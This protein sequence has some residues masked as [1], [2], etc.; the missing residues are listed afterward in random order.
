[1]TQSACNGSNSDEKQRTHLPNP[2]AYVSPLR[3]EAVPRWRPNRGPRG[4]IFGW[5]LPLQLMRK[6]CSLERSCVATGQGLWLLFSGYLPPL[7]SS[8]ASRLPITAGSRWLPIAVCAS[9][10]GDSRR[11]NASAYCQQLSIGESKFPLEV[12]IEEAPLKRRSRG[13]RSR[14]P[15][16]KVLA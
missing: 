4:R 11:M 2:A 15:G 8:I 5:E 12:V 16:R 10:C 7:S 9:P 1:M 14:D 13:A 6:L 3:L